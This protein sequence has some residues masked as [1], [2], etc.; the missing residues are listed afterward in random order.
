M[1]WPQTPAKYSS[2]EIPFLTHTK[3]TEL[4]S[5]TVYFALLERTGMYKLYCNKSHH[6]QMAVIYLHANL[7]IKN[8]FSYT[9]GQWGR[10]NSQPKVATRC[11]DS[12]R[13]VLESF[14]QMEGIC[15]RN[16]NFRNTNRSLQ[17]RTV[18]TKQHYG[19]AGRRWQKSPPTTT[20][21]IVNP[22]F[23]NPEPKSPA[24][25]Q[26]RETL[27]SGRS[28]TLAS[29]HFPLPSPR[30]LPHLLLHVLYN[31]TP[32]RHSSQGPSPRFSS[33]KISG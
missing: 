23:R 13:K 16:W 21:T 6:W 1:S 29:L 14:L 8:C 5:C 10:H 12:G 2:A 27:S 22:S 33:L 32:K 31:I 25:N 15:K 18:A 9:V 24:R 3:H 19:M 26:G 30:C 7:M 20:H 28:A 17:G 11:M 4:D